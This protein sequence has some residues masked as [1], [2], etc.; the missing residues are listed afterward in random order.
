MKNYIDLSVQAEYSDAQL[1]ITYVTSPYSK[2]HPDWI[3]GILEDGVLPVK[4]LTGAEALRMLNKRVAEGKLSVFPAVIMEKMVRSNTVKIT[5]TSVVGEKN[6]NA[7]YVVEMGVLTRPDNK[8][9][10]LASVTATLVAYETVVLED[11]KKR[12]ICEMVWDPVM[13]PQLQMSAIRNL[14][15]KDDVPISHPGKAQ[16]NFYSR[17]ISKNPNAVETVT[18]YYAHSL[19][20]NNLPNYED[21]LDPKVL[22][23]VNTVRASLKKAPMSKLCRI[24]EYNPNLKITTI[25]DTAYHWYSA[26]LGKRGSNG[27]RGPLTSGYTMFDMPSVLTRVIS[28]VR[29]ILNLCTVFGSNLVLTD[30]LNVEVRRVLVANGVSVFVTEGDYSE[31]VNDK[32]GVYLYTD[33]VK[34]GFVYFNATGPATM[35]HYSSQAWVYK[36]SSNE[37]IEERLEKNL[38]YAYVSHLNP[39]MANRI[40]FPTSRPDRMEAIVVKRDREVVGFSFDKITVRCSMGVSARTCFPRYRSP[41]WRC[42]VMADYMRWDRPIIYPQLKGDRVDFSDFKTWEGANFVDTSEMVF[43]TPDKYAKEV[44]VNSTV[45]AVVPEEHVVLKALKELIGDVNSDPIAVQGCFDFVQTYE[46]DVP[47]AEKMQKLVALTVNMSWGQVFDSLSGDPRLSAF[48]LRSKNDY[49]RIRNE[50][51][52]TERSLRRKEQRRAK[53]RPEKEE[54]GDP[55]PAISSIPPEPAVDPIPAESEDVVVDENVLAAMTNLLNVDF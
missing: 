50:R 23:N 24:R 49:V 21:H 17:L 10:V 13:V 25:L 2:D 5:P 27:K 20:G 37:M 12:K 28:E 9:S 7:N 52:A 22:I 8:L 1:A 40:L 16:V 30:S 41:F 6:S 32:P 43:E 53:G 31:A 51:M 33:Q 47:V 45:E 42:E 34:I 39:F 38:N 29:D 4:G 3:A 55:S 54:E 26:N 18:L 35:P 15:F 48:L 46:R 19:A 14:L 36:N 44:K 11:G